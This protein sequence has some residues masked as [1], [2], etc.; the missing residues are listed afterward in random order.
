[1]PFTSEAQ[2]R[3]MWATNPKVAAKMAESGPNSGL[4]NYSKTSNIEKR[5]R[6]TGE[7]LTPT[8]IKKRLQKRKQKRKKTQKKRVKKRKK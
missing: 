4:P 1:M 2:R 8:Q 7:N 6:I 3:F 5:D